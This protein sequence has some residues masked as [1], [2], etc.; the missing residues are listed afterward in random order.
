MKLTRPLIILASL[1]AGIAAHAQMTHSHVQDSLQQI[2]YKVSRLGNHYC[3]NQGTSCSLFSKDGKPLSPFKYRSLK[4]GFDGYFLAS[5]YEQGDNVLVLDSLGREISPMV[6]IMA[7]DTAHKLYISGRN[8]LKANGEML[9]YHSSYGD[10]RTKLIAVSNYAEKCVEIRDSFCNVIMPCQP[11]EYA[12]AGNKYVAAQRGDS[13]FV[14]NDK[15]SLLFSCAA[16]GCQIF[17]NDFI[18]IR[19]YGMWALKDSAGRNLTPYKYYRLEPWIYNAGEYIQ[20]NGGLLDRKGREVIAPGGSFI[21]AELGGWYEQSREDSYYVFDEHFKLVLKARR[22]DFIGDRYIKVYKDWGDEDYKLFDRKKR[23]F[24]SENITEALTTEAFEVFDKTTKKFHVL[25]KGRVLKLPE[26]NK[27]EKAGERGGAGGTNYFMIRL[28]EGQK[29][30]G[31][32][33][34]RQSGWLAGFDEQQLCGVLDS[35]M[36]FV[37]PMKYR[38]IEIIGKNVFKV[39]AGDNKYY[40]VKKGGKVICPAQEYFNSSANGTQYYI[41]QTGPGTAAVIDSAGNLL[42]NGTGLPALLSISDAKERWNVKPVLLTYEDSLGNAGVYDLAGRQLL[43]HQYRVVPEKLSG[44]FSLKKNDSL[45]FINAAGKMLFSGRGFY[46]PKTMLLGSY[47]AITMGTG[48]YWGVIKPD[49]NALVPFEYDTA[50]TMSSYLSDYNKSTVVLGKKHSYT[51]LD[52]AGRTIYADEPFMPRSYYG[53]TVLQADNGHYYRVG[54]GKAS[55]MGIA[56]PRWGARGQTVYTEPV[57]VVRERENKAA[58]GIYNQNERLIATYYPGYTYRTYGAVV[59]IADSSGKYRAVLD[60]SGV[61]TMPYTLKPDVLVINRQCVVGIYKNRPDTLYQIVNGRGQKLAIKVDSLSKLQLIRDHR[62]SDFAN[63]QAI[64]FAAEG[65]RGVIPQNGEIRI[66]PDIDS[67]SNRDKRIVRVK[68]KWGLLDDGGGWRVAPEY[69]SILY[70]EHYGYILNKNGRQGLWAYPDKLIPA[71]YARIYTEH[72]A[73]DGFILVKDSAGVKAIDWKAR[74]VTPYFDS[75]NTYA[76]TLT[77]DAYRG[78]KTYELFIDDRG[79]VASKERDARNNKKDKR[80]YWQSLVIVK[81]DGQEGL[82]NNSAQRWLIPPRFGHLEE[83]DDHYIGYVFNGKDKSRADSTIIYNSDGTLMKAL[84]GQYVI[85]RFTS[86]LWAL[87]GYNRSPIISDE[88]KVVVPAGFDYAEA[89]AGT[90]SLIV[91][92]KEEGKKRKKG[93]YNANGIMTIP[94]ILDDIGNE[95]RDQL[96]PGYL[97][98]NIENPDTADHDEYYLYCLI[99]PEGIMLT[100]PIYAEIL[101][102]A[103]YA[104]EANP[105]FF[106][107][108]HGKYGVIDAKGKQQ[109][110]MVY[111]KVLEVYK[112][113]LAIVKKGDKWGMVD[114]KNKI[115]APFI[116]DDIS[117][118]SLDKSSYLKGNV[119]GWLDSRGKEGTEGR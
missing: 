80:G 68:G 115:L 1:L 15:G 40:L 93:L 20:G 62:S 8:L 26:F 95:A 50:F 41:T 108:R 46:G 76:T 3:V 13:A 71:A 69:D 94:T 28:V 89:V 110:P 109:L 102:N 101:L 6:N 90:S 53:D 7:M 99:S 57:R 27:L 38:G 32:D 70:N 106:V 56:T 35:E 12:T 31:E 37:L 114:M 49:G 113:K 63:D 92:T 78:G 111:D 19:R 112:N 42:Y 118:M 52:D 33:E 107:K 97:T 86:G 18:G 55:D 100:K 24:V 82:Y 83:E 14:Y 98:G 9:C 4:E 75:M 59:V 23:D 81:E 60:S 74:S 22:T 51:V 25:Y 61:Y 43:P 66:S 73:G 44:L 54:D 88:G 58:A 79:E 5:Y 105:N 104:N 84:A 117:V 10:Y 48:Q 2:Y 39:L 65:K 72:G 64:A 29:Y 103:Y 77:M 119:S 45:Y 96:G 47:V 17:P 21:S 67:V 87:G 16:S 91:V 116:Y 36:N 11:F 30:M 85:E 34:D